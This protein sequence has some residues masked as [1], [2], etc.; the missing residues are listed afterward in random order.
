MP[1]YC[2]DNVMCADMKCK[3]LHYKTMEERQ[4]I[5][6]IFEDNKEE[7]SKFMEEV[8]PKIW[9]CRYHLLCYEATCK[10][11][12]SGYALDARK[13]IKKAIRKEEQKEKIAKEIASKKAGEKLV[14]ADECQ[15]CGEVGK[16]NKKGMVFVIYFYKE[17]L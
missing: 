16:N 6:K 4:R 14:W 5:R 15:N 2:N 1:N 12:H 13:V 9:N 8:N 3:F 7:M 11:N 17:L 10:N